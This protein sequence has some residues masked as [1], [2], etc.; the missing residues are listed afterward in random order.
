MSRG[1]R[2]E[3]EGKRER[4]VREQVCSRVCVIAESD[5]VDEGDEGSDGCEM[6]EA[7]DVILVKESQKGAMRMLSRDTEACAAGTTACRESAGES[8]SSGN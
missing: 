6:R 8:V 1:E 2:S 5:R 4:E 7:G 3:E